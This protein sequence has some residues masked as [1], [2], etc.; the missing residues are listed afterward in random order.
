MFEVG[1]YDEQYKP[2]DY[3]LWVRIVRK[4]NLA[5]LNQFLLKHRVSNT[6]QSRKL[7][8]LVESD[9]GKII[10]ANIHHYLP[11]FKKEELMPLVRMLQY[12]P[13]KSSEDGLKVLGA[14]TGFFEKYTDVD[15]DNTRAKNIQTK[16]VLFY[17]LQLFKTNFT[18]S[19]VQ[20]IKLLCR[21][22]DILLDG[23]F[24]RK[25]ARAMLT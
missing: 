11:S 22:P 15:G 14:F 7:K 9:C 12:K 10:M 4:Y 25:I 13:Q 23:K 18:Y 20:L 24:Y 3:D 19:L 21:N 17:L 8:D 6:Q 16:M 5:N 1:L 2:H